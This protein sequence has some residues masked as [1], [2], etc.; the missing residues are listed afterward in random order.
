[1]ARVVRYTLTASVNSTVI[2][3]G[4]CRLIGVIIT[5]TSTQRVVKIYDLGTAPGTSDT[6]IMTVNSPTSASN[7]GSLP[8]IFPEPV[9][10]GN[11]CGIRIT[12]AFA[13]TDATITG[14]DG[15]VHFIFSDSW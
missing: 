6:P 8:I 15:F 3:A 7:V 14:T 10:L 13:D 2:K 12:A 5:P 11:G 9:L 1:M 4:R